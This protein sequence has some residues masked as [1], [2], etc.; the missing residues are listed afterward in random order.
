MKPRAS[1]KQARHLLQKP[2]H[3]IADRE[4]AQF[5]DLHEGFLELRSGRRLEQRLGDR[6]TR[7]II[8][9]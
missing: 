4:V 1:R 6:V 9:K 7:H 2:G 3:A 8:A 5:P